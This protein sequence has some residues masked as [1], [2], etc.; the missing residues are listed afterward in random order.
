MDVSCEPITQFL[1][2]SDETQFGPLQFVGGMTMTSGSWDF[3]AFS[4]LR[5]L[6]PGSSFLGVAD[7]GYWYSG[8]I[9][10]DA[11]GRPTCVDDFAMTAIAGADGQ[12]LKGKDASDAEGLDVRA[13]VATASFEREHRITEY[14]LKPD[15]M[16]GPI[17]NLDFLVPRGELRRNRGFETVAHAPQDS[18]SAGA[19]VAISEMSLDA[20]GNC[21]AAI[22][23]GPRK[24]IFKVKRGGEF[25]ITDGAFLPGGDMLILE[26]RFSF[27]GGVAM[28]LRRLKGETIRPGA[29]ADGPVLLEAD[30]SYDID[31]MEGLDVWRRGD[32]A[33]IVSL[34]SDD[35]RSIIQR[36]VY[37]EFR[38]AGE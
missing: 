1:I 37:L 8:R 23:E 38:L 25:D 20:D 28:R 34:I 18:P 30:M 4:A 10:R 11:G 15:A 6:D 22:L 16:G 33:L 24:G 29:L 17:R 32:G 31:N 12:P 2:G 19:R 36:N 35:N 27:V 26:R 7:T 5:F 3:G 13:G 21:F 14:G 9:R